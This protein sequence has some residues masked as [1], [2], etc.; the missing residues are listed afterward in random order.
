MFQNIERQTTASS[1]SYDMNQ[2]LGVIYRSG[3]DI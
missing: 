1:N 3:L 2:W